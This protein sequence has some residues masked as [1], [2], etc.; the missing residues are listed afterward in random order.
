MASRN[1]EKEVEECINFLM[2][3]L[4][5]DLVRK[6]YSDDSEAYEAMC[7]K[8]AFERIER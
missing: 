6:E 1:F 7:L 2:T 8:H 4:K 3:I 5:N